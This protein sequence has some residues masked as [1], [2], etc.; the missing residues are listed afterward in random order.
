MQ[1]PLTIRQPAL[2]SMSVGAGGVPSLSLRLSRLLCYTGPEPYAVEG[3]DYDLIKQ[4]KFRSV[5][6]ERP[7]EDRV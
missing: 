4:Q 7:P 1:L 5:N 6:V 2:W 3:N